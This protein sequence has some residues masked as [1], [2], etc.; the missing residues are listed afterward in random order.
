[1]AG[2]STVAKISTNVRFWANRTLARLSP[3][4]ADRRA[5][6]QWST[7]FRRVPPSAPPGKSFRISSG[8]YQ[9]SAWD[10]GE[11]PTVLLVHGWNGHT[12]QM[13]AFVEPL[14]A[15]G[16]H[17]VGFDQPAH[18]G[19]TGDRA[20]LVSMVE[21]VRSV[22]WRVRPLHAVI[23][24]SLGATAVALALTQDVRVERSVLMAPPVEMTHHVR[25][26]AKAMGFS[27]EGML[28]ELRHTLG[29]DLD[30]FDL[31]RHAPAHRT[32]ILVL[33]DPEDKEVPFAP[34]RAFAEIWPDTELQ[35]VAGAGH[36]RM[37][38]NPAVVSAA[39][40]F[41]NGSTAI[42]SVRAKAS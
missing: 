37:L 36:R 40:E 10:E 15:A 39:I 4:E 28:R 21:A 5:V 1:M 19:S 12:G 14:L 29:T 7:P 22:A 9:L 11:G 3:A 26:F 24:H 35:T 16:Y 32:P 2:M 17:V 25:G 13:R 30:S 38:A 6:D 31:R 42:S 23:A 20:T 27:A 34:A 18:G 33:H 41:V 8:L